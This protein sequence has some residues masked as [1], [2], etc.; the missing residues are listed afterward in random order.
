MWVRQEHEVDFLE[1]LVR[2]NRYQ[3]KTFGV[4]PFADAA[5][6]WY[7]RRKLESLGLDPPTTWDELRKAGHALVENGLARADGDARRCHGRG[8]DRVL[9]DRGVGL[10]RRARARAGGVSLGSRSTAQA[11]RFLRRLVEERIVPPEVV[12]YGWDHAVQLMAE[13]RPLSA[14]VGSTRLRLSPRRSE[15]ITTT[16]GSTSASRESP[17]AR[18][19]RR[20]ASQ[21]G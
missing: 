5:G 20:R 6:L 12:G 9:P 3:G 10:E 18:R 1:P 21:A 11:L 8:D 14:W 4:S 16:S 2:A 13:G 19:D 7:A 17:P 15:S